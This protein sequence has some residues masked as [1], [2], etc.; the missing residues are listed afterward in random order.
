[1]H[2]P[3]S[4]AVV[5]A[6]IVS[7]AGC[8]PSSTPT[9]L[10]Q[11]G[12]YVVLLGNDTIAVDQFSRT[13]NRV[14]GVLLQ[15]SPR[16]L[17]TRYV[18]TLDDRGLPQQFEQS[19]RLADGSIPPNAAR[20][21]TVT[22]T[23]DSAVSRIQRDTL[24][25]IPVAARG[26][27]P[28]LGNAFS[29]YALPIAALRASGRDSLGGFIVPAG[30]RSPTQLSVLKKGKN[31]YWAYLFSF[32][33]EFTT[34]DAGQIQTF[35]GTRTTV[36]VV[37]RRQDPFDVAALATAW[38]A[39]ERQTAAMGVLSPRDTVR[40]AIGA[41]QLWVD[42]SRPS[43]RGRKVFAANGVFGDTIWRTGANAAT[44]F[45]TNVPLTV[46]GQTLPA[47][48]YTL[49]T[50]AIPGRYQLIFNRQVGQWGTEYKA[51][52]D[53]VRV[54]LTVTT[55]ISPVDRFT[56]V[57]EPNGDKAGVLRLQWDTTELSVPF[58]TP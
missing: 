19:A 52:Q 38:A 23:A 26:G 6:L 33:F 16:V 30:T 42:Y 10:V 36:H 51:D 32:P 11:S 48:I 29:L 22:F 3:P 4:L 39:R 43:A 56:I 55:L 27:W 35:N 41:A 34:D 20:S 28:F 50:V 57:A 13:G 1:M 45:R 7:A 12:A 2:R 5:V 37:G 53:L 47:G 9:P 24:T 40:A 49:W 25:T 58:T 15:R 14:E 54:P 8:H 21:A 44:Q 17:V 18:A 31:H 46:A